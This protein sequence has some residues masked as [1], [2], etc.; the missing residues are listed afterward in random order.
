MIFDFLFLYVKTNDNIWCFG[1]KNIK[2]YEI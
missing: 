1:V 2:Y